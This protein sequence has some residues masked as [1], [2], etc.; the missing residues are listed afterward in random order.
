MGGL[1]GGEERLLLDCELDEVGGWVGGW[2]G[3][4]GPS[5][6]LLFCCSLTLLCIYVPAS[7]HA[8]TPSRGRPSV[9]AWARVGRW[10]RRRSRE[11]EEARSRIFCSVW[12]WVGGWDG[13]LA[14]SQG[15]SGV[16]GRGDGAGKDEEEEGEEEEERVGPSLPTYTQARRV[17]GRAAMHA[18]IGRARVYHVY[19]YMYRGRKGE[20]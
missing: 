7:I 15:M 19:M 5:S 10:R 8:L 16:V 17:S 9:W 2:V 11:E 18:C 14:W 3:G 12:R 20:T 13:V 4:T 1:V 6:G